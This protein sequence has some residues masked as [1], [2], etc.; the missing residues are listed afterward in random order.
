MKYEMMPVIS[1]DDLE[2]ALLAQYGID[3]TGELASFLF[4]DSYINDSYKRY[5][6]DEMEEFTGKP[7][8]DEESIRIE[9][10]VKSILQDVLPEHKH[11]LIDVSW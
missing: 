6:F 11:C 2:A 8:Q 3:W 10:C 7:W 5:W 9:N 1:I 4:G